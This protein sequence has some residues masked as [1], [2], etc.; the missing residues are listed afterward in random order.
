MRVSAGTIALVL[1]SC[2]SAQNADRVASSGPA[3]AFD[4]YPVRE[5]NAWA[6]DVID[7]RLEG[8]G[9]VLVTSRMV[10]VTPTQFTIDSVRERVTYDVVADG[11]FKPQSQYHLLK[12]PI[13]KGARWEIPV[14]GTVRIAEVGVADEVPAGKFPDCIVVVEILG[15]IHKVEWTYARDVGPV[16]MRVYDLREGEPELVIEGQ[17]RSYVTEPLELPDEGVTPP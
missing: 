9:P 5:G 11:I 7:H 1:V 2:A 10:D 17:L 13:E 3:T 14:G 12:S 4:Y 16:R 6:H 15:D 8:Q